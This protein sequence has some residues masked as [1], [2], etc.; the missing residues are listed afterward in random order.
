MDNEMIE[1][2]LRE[3]RPKP[4][5]RYY[6]TLATS[7]WQ[8]ELDDIQKQLPTKMPHYRIKLAVAFA[9]ALF[10]LALATSPRVLATIEHVLKSVGNQDFAL[11]ELSPSDADASTLP[12][13]DVDASELA[14][15]GIKLPTVFPDSNNGE[16]YIARKTDFGAFIHYLVQ[17]DAEMKNLTL[18]VFSKDDLTMMFGTEVNL[19]EVVLA[20]GTVAVVG[21]GGWDIESR[22]FVQ[23]GTMLSWRQDGYKYT[24]TTGTPD[25]VPLL[26]EIANSF[27]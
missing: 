16:I 26:I 12:Y 15:L 5:T 8:T 22:E 14:A 11:T 23:L 1:E 20:D 10:C 19:E 21:G 13:V 9:V 4:T 2:R 24:L 17:Y 25:K 7:P 18:E 3:I 27:E 6:Q